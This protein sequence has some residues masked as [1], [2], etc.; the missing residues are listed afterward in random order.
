MSV[1]R[2]CRMSFRISVRGSIISACIF[3]RLTARIRR[4]L[5]TLESRICRIS[6]VPI[7]R[8]RKENARFAYVSVHVVYFVIVYVAFGNLEMT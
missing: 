7:V 2:V 6:P 8:L 3:R 1:Q 5:G 4:V